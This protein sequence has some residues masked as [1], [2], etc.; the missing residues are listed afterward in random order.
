[1][2]IPQLHARHGAAERQ[3]SGR[4]VVL[5]KGVRLNQ[6]VGALDRDHG[7]ALLSGNRDG[8]ALSPNHRGTSL[9]AG[10]KILF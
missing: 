1:M 8:Q 7:K 9:Y 3:I 2:R 10:T 5:I 6:L 4:N